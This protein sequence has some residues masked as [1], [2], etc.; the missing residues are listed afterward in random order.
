SPTPGTYR[1]V[2]FPTTKP[3]FTGAVHYA[4]YGENDLSVG[5]V[6]PRSA[7][8]KPG[9]SA[10]FT[11]HTRTSK[12]P[13]DL[14]QTLRF[15]NQAGPVRVIERSLLHPTVKRAARFSTTITGGNARPSLY[16]LANFYQFNVPKGVK[17]IDV[18]VALG[19]SGYLMYGVLVDPKQN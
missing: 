11:V 17:D 14:A 6:T 4:V 2:V 3:F 7:T 5:T 18:N 10:T 16:G 13:G 9:K 8:L 19:H 12:A 1:L 15:G